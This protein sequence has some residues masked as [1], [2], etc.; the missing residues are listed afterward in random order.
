MTKMGFADTY[1]KWVKLCVSTVHYSV[2]INHD[3]A[4]PFIGGGV[5]TR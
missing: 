1:V 3:F 5:E 2:L 4:G